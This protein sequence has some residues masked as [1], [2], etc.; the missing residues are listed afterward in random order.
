ML[1]MRATS[2]QFVFHVM[3]RITVHEPM[4]NI[5]L[6]RRILISSI[7]KKTGLKGKP[8]LL[9]SPQQIIP[10]STATPSCLIRMFS[11]SPDGKVVAYAYSSRSSKW[12]YI[13]FKEVATGKEYPEVLKNVCHSD[14]SWTRDQSRTGIVGILYSVTMPPIKSS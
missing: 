11:V 7:Y 5:S 6:T 14:I 4:N 2:K 9:V 13:R 10:S 1:K 3:N 8:E 12:L